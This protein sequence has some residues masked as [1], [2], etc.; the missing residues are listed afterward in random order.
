MKNKS[1]LLTWILGGLSVAAAAAVITIASASKT[2]PPSLQSA[3]AA[4]AHET[5]AP[6]S[7]P[8]SAPATPAT[9]ATMAAVLPV[10]G[11][12]VEPEPALLT[13][14]QSQTAV[15]PPAPSGQ[16][17][18]CTTNGIKTFSNNPCGEKSTLI[19]VRPI[20]TMNATPPAR[21]AR[22]SGPGPHFVPAYAE[23]N[24]YPDQDAYAEQS[25]PE[26]AV[27]SY[28]V[29]RGYAFRRGPDRPHRPPFHHDPDHRSLD[30]HSPGP[31][32]RR[33]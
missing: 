23:Q 30:H 17:W 11:P 29:V 32:M 25:A 13:S 15:E 7:Q 5:A 2:V 27:I 4:T 24:S 14:A 6:V 8:L 20:N 12:L 33:F 28:G 21:Y 3:S 19:D 31:M 26:P 16:I 9:V 10:T 1:N 18:E 22:T